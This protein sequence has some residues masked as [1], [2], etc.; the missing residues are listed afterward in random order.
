MNFHCFFLIKK[1]YKH[2]YLKF[3]TS[4][5]MYFDQLIKD[6]EAYKNHRSDDTTVTN[7]DIILLM[8]RYK[9]R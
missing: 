3:F 7:Q 6:I 2:T 5:N 9:N 8:K 1:N 4:K